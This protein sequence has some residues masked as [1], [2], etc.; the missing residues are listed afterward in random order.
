MTGNIMIIDD[1]PIDR[2]II[3]QILKKKLLEINLF[4]AEDGLNINEK[5]V[6]NNI[7]MC[8]LDI[9]LPM[10]DGFQIL[11]DMK[12]DLRLADMPVIVCTGL[13]D[14]QAIEKALILGAY[15]YFSKPFSEDAMKISLP[16][17]VRNAIEFMKRKE[18]II[19]LSY[20]DKLTGLYNR[21]FYEE[22]IKRL[23][24]EENLPISIIMGDVN[25]LKITND[26]FGHEAGDRLLKKTA[27]ILKSVC[28]KN[29]IMARTGGDEFLIILPGT[30]AEEAGKIVDRIKGKCI[31]GKEDPARP[32]VSVGFSVK[33]S[34]DQDI[35]AIYKAAEDKMYSIKHM[36]NESTINSIVSLLRKTLYKHTLEPEEHDYLSLIEHIREG[37]SSYAM[38]SD[39]EGK[40]GGG[41]KPY[42]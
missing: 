11:A 37:L 38:I 6:I 31:R 15:D 5:L 16:L 39:D 34:M 2:K 4:E 36:E 10:K 12:E 24:K 9:M 17:K 19:Y 22:E 18:E 30:D 26:I 14:K 35:S 41:I 28:R 29:D 21:R 33:N 23:D 1:S 25:G 32:S 8:I 3:R 13:D 42:G 40:S 27:D 7:H 20:H